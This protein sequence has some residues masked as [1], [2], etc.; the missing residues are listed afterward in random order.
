MLCFRTRRMNMPD[1][2][3]FCKDMEE[4]KEWF[5]RLH[6]RIFEE[7]EKLSRDYELLFN[8]SSRTVYEKNRDWILSLMKY[9]NKNALLHFYPEGINYYWTVNIEY[10]ILDAVNRAREIATVQIDVGN[11][12]RFGIEFTDENG[13][14]RKPIILHTAILGTLERLLYTLLD[15][16]IQKG[17]RLPLWL[18]PE[19]VRILT[20]G[21]KHIEKGLSIAKE[22]ESNS[23]R[24][25]LDDRAESIAR[26]VRD[27]KTDWVGY[28]VVIGDR[29][30][31]SETLNVYSREE[32]RNKEYEL[33]ELIEEIK[34]ETEGKPF[35]KLYFPREMC[36]RPVFRG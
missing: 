9:K 10:H 25:G 8:F 16:A 1:L 15:T 3:V 12:E 29:E 21:D 26:K 36:K 28:I 7:I 30:L 19:Q 33:Q 6:Q 20:V 32:N 23:I 24:V 35:R 5:F 13:K 17:D 11:A 2:H 18:N 14:E 31:K 34:K 4:A 22:L 27:A